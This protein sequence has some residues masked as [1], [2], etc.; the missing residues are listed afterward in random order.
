MDLN[1]KQIE[2]VQSI[3]FPTLI[4]AVPGAGKTR[5][6]VEKYLYL[7][8]LGYLTEKLVAITYTNKAANEMQERLKNRIPKFINYPYISTIHSFALRLMVENKDLFNFRKGSTVIDQEDSQQIIEQIIINNRLELISVEETYRFINYAKETFNKQLIL[9]CYNNA[10]HLLY[11]KTKENTFNFDDYNDNIKQKIFV[12]TEYQKYLYKSALFDYADLILYPLL[13]MEL[14][15]TIKE[16]IRNKFDYILVD[17]YQDINKLQNIFLIAISNGANITAVGDEDQSIYGFRGATIEP[18]MNFEKYFHNAKIIYMD[19]N[20]RSKTKIINSANKVISKNKI[21]R[22]KNTKAIRNEEGEV[23]VSLFDSESQMIDFIIDKIVYLNKKNISYEKIAILTRTSWLLI[24]IQNRFLEKYIPYKMLRGV[25]FFERKEIKYTIYYISFMLNL[26]NDFL[27]SKISS[28]PKRGIGIKTIEK[29]KEEKEKS[30]KNFLEICL[31]INNSKVNEFAKFLET[32]FKEKKISD[33]CYKLMN[34]GRF[35]EEWE[36][37]G[38][39]IFIDRKEN[40]ELLINIANQ[41]EKENIE[42]KDNIFEI[43]LSKIIPF[44]KNEENTNSIILGTL[45]SAKGL[46]FNAVFLPYVSET[47][48]PY[49]RNKEQSDIE[50]ERR[51]LYVGMTRAKDF[52]YIMHSNNIEFRSSDLKISCLIEPLIPEYLAEDK[53]MTSKFKIGDY[54]E[55]PDYGSGKIIEIK[56]LRNGK[57]VYIVEND[58]GIMQ[59]ID[60]IHELNKKEYDF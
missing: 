9:Y 7:Y 51:L 15:E 57:I 23:E 60:G 52:L 33:F 59:F 13:T 47:I 12:F 30:S 2:A 20:Y 46:E 27:F 18:I 6:I 22:N 42:R 43:F 34:D 37:E 10:H 31:S 40:F 38:E 55:S 8:N 14:D 4:I 21:R 44:F 3:Q 5:V 16:R 19:E 1:S 24:K 53:R 29:I 28:Y 50:E 11:L 39:D 45:H 25:N 26:D 41:I 58:D 32:L 49:Q 17:E 36:K 35:L 48:L 54:I 56:R